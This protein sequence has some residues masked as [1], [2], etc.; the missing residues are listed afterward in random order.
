MG[1]KL[2]LSFPADN[3]G[4]VSLAVSDTEVEDALKLVD[5][6][7]VSSGF[8]REQN[9]DNA[10]VQDFV[11]SYSKLD[12]EGMRHETAG[13]YLKANLLEV[14]FPEGRQPSAEKRM[15]VNKMLDLVKNKLSRRYG[16]DRIKV[17]T[18]KS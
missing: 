18:V 14:V 3:Q 5:D 11:A 10:G 6:A 1:R 13:V 4:S 8:M 12:G 17:V 16:T 15:S 9:P 7:L 2:I